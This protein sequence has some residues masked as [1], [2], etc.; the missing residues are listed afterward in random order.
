MKN[1]KL[2]YVLITTINITCSQH[3][4]RSCRRALVE[5]SGGPR[6]SSLDRLRTA[7]AQFS[8]SS[9]WEPTTRENPLFLEAMTNAKRLRRV[10]LVGAPP[11][12]GHSDLYPDLA[13]QSTEQVLERVCLPCCRGLRGNQGS[14]LLWCSSSDELDWMAGWL[15][16]HDQVKFLC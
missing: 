2:V 16:G 4:T 6:E 15:A 13:N 1:T 9:S 12:P 11:A 10:I 8:K 3:R 5:P 14:R 7:R